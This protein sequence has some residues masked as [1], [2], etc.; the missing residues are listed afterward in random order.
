MA[1]EPGERM[2]APDAPADGT[3]AR[4]GR[5]RWRRWIGWAALGLAALA[6]VIQT[7][8][9]GRDHSNPP[10]VATPA[11]DSARTQ[12]LFTTACGDCHSNRTRWPW[13]TNVAPASWLVQRDVE[14]GRGALNV[15]DLN[16]TEVEMDEVEEVIREGEM[17]PLQYRLIHRG[18]SLDAGEREDLIAGLRA[19]F[20]Q[21]PVTATPR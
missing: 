16:A 2:T 13:Y 12:A 4:P 10:E 8:P 11:W 7:V 9:Y 3:P 6:A 5:I 1:T 21:P 17:P 14:E 18:A 15:S 19:T 20:A